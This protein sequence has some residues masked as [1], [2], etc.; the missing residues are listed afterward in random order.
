MLLNGDQLS[1]GSNTYS[2]VQV[3]MT[4]GPNCL[5][6]PPYTA[7]RPFDAQCF[8]AVSKAMGLPH[9]LCSMVIDLLFADKT[10]DL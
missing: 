9:L 8:S 7:K 6:A 5:D 4:S 2:Q 3:E 1:L 10:V